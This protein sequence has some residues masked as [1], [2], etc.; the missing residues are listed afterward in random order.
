MC[1]PFSTSFLI[2]A[3]L[4]SAFPSFGV[5]LFD[6]ARNVQHVVLTGAVG[7]QPRTWATLRLVCP[8]DVGLPVYAQHPLGSHI[9]YPLKHL[10]AQRD[11][12]R[13]QTQQRIFEAKPRLPVACHSLAHRRQSAEHV[14]IDDMVVL[15][16]AVLV[17]VRQVRSG[18]R[19]EHADGS[20]LS[21]AGGQAA[22]D[23]TQRLAAPRLQNSITTNWL[24]QVMHLAYFSP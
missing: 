19:L 10:Q 13:L 18:W 22:D 21:I 11:C 24:Q 20:Q 4:L 1:T 23:L 8:L 6:S 16:R 9:H 7:R 17:G 2:I 5:A 12:R 14:L 3:P 15:P